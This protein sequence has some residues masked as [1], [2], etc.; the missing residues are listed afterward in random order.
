[1]LDDNHRIAKVAEPAQGGQQTVDALMQAMGFIQN[2]QHAVKPEPICEASR[3]RWLSPPDRVPEARQ[4]E[5]IQTDIVKEAEPLV[6][7]LRIRAAICLS[8]SD[9]IVSRL[10]NQAPASMI[11]NSVMSLIVSRRINRQTRV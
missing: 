3:M 6:D 1:M 10:A 8:L 11:E 2:I 9:K 4:A 7:F 5:I